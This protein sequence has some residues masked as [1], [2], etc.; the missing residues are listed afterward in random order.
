MHVTASTPS[1][2]RKPKTFGDTERDFGDG[3]ATGIEAA[4]AV[5]GAAPF[6]V[7]RAERTRMP[8][9]NCHARLRH[10]LRHT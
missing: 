8:A 1:C 10:V 5:M 3:E 7:D 2:A 6:G 9:Q 4:A